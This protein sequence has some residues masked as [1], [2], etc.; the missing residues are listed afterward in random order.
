[1]A[2]QEP[3]WTSHRPFDASLKQVLGDDLT[4]GLRAFGLNVSG[5]PR[6]VNTD[7]TTVFTTAADRVILIEQRDQPVEVIHLEFQSSADPTLPERLSV[8]NGHCALRFKVE[9]VE[10][11][12]IL[13]RP[14]ANLK[15]LNGVHKRKTRR[16]RQN[17]RFTY[18]VIRLYELNPEPF[19]TGPLPMLALAPFTR[20][21]QDRLGAM[22]DR[23]RERL[24]TEGSDR[25]LVEVLGLI[26]TMAGLRP[27]PD[28]A[29]LLT[30]RIRTMIDL[31]HS[32]T[33]RELVEEGRSEGAL[34]KAREILLLQGTRR[35]GP[36]GEPTRQQITQCAHLDRIEKALVAILTASSWQDLEPHLKD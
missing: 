31:R 6:L 24:V 20:V 36:P 13:L 9:A 12:V 35:F 5:Q 15:V 32:S 1:M 11:V 10:S 2:G 17:L 34:E 3:D 21:A 19:L 27:E 29:S 30:R 4:G 8:Y 25:D 16:R 14:A 22:L 18:R 26:Y 33:A 23:I 28:A 7:L